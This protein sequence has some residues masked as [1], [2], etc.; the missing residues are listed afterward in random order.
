MTIELRNE[1][2]QARSTATLT[3]LTEAARELADEIGFE[4][5]T[6]A[7]VALRAGTSIGTVYRYFPDRHA[8]VKAIDPE[9]R[10]TVEVR[11]ERMRQNAKWGEQNHPDGTGISTLLLE[12]ELVETVLERVR[13]ELN[14]DAASGNATWAQILYEEFLEALAESDPAKLRA[15][16]IQVQAV[17]QQ[18]VAAIDR[19]NS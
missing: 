19:R 8:I 18:W 6:T 14:D 3:R 16:L 17:A 9:H 4:R 2:Q 5:F 1:P 11:A 13:D 12:G 15:E 7:D 10:I